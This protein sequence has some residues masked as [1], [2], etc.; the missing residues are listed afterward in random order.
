VDYKSVKQTVLGHVEASEFYLV[1]KLA[2]SVADICLADP[3]VKKVDVTIDKPGALRFAR[4]V[5]VA[6]TR[7][8]SA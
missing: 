3:R 4:S 5:A 2:D 6:I 8:R 7:E 1:E